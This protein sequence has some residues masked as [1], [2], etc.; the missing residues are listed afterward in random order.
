MLTDIL[1]TGFHGALTADVKPGSTV[2][3]AGADPV[4]LAAAASA[5]LLSAA[6]IMIGDMNE[7]RLKPRPK[8]WL[9]PDRSQQARSPQRAYSCGRR[10]THGQFGHRCS[11]S[12]S[13]GP[14]RRRPARHRSEP[15]NGDHPAGWRHRHTGIVWASPPNSCSTRT[16]CWSDV[17]D[18]PAGRGLVALESDVR[19]RLPRPLG[20]SACRKPPIGIVLSEGPGRAAPTAA[21]SRRRKR[22]KA[23]KRPWHMSTGQCEVRRSP[24]ATAISVV[25]VSS[26]PC[27]PT[28]TAAR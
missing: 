25:L 24:I 13:Q 12:R 1:P 14:R 28:A 16:T 15:G 11:G 3:V 27:R 10:R 23:R 9:R 17:A 4:G 5:Q 8:R 6:V 7:A 2:Y 19:A 18:R 26:I 20:P 22:T 21:R